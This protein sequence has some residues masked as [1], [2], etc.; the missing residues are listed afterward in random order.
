M[1]S[2]EQRRDAGLP[3]NRGIQHP[4]LCGCDQQRV[5]A[6]VQGVGSSQWR[7]RTALEITV[8]PSVVM[9]LGIGA[10]RLNSFGERIS[11]RAKCGRSCL[12]PAVR[13]TIGG[14][15]AIGRNGWP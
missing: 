10:V 15:G 1:L 9:G 14:S 5:S 7:C 12:L 8:C 2:S 13:R 11:I 3:H 6:W 4:D